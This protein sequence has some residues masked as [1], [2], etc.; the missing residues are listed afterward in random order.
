MSRSPLK[1]FVLT[2]VVLSAAV[3]GALTLPLAIFGSK[4]VMIQVQQEQVYQ[5]QLKDIAAPYLG[6]AGLISLGVGIANVAV[7][8]WQVSSRQSSQV[9]AKL[10]TLEQN[11]KEKEELLEELKLSESRLE[12]SG[13]RVFLDEEVTPQLAEKAPAASLATSNQVEPLVITTQPVEALPVEARPVSVQAAAQRFVSSQTFL[14]FAR[15]K[16]AIELSN[17]A[18]SVTPKDVEQLHT[19][20]QQIMAQMASLQMALAA[21]PLAVESEEAVST[22]HML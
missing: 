18:Q 19:Q 5:G 17:Q 21:T 9:E 16:N 10:S 8:G 22:Q 1:K 3:F 15:T 20:L 4:P 12:A 2:P 14:G 6:L 13:L 7:L 11:L